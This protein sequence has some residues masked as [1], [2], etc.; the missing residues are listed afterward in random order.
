MIYEND[1]VLEAV[2]AIQNNDAVKLGQLMVDSHS[3]LNTM[4]NI[5]QNLP[6]CYGA[7]MTG[8][9]FGGCAIALVQKD[10]AE[11]FATQVADEFQ[12]Q[13]GLTPSIYISMAT[14]GC[15]VALSSC[16]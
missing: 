15:R 7:R 5:A 11:P 3:S 14:E 6:A 9:G 4:V 8:A 16:V 2:I 1:R 10:Q 13:S 12:K